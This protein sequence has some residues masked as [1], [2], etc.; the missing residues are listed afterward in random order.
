M[1][2]TLKFDQ[3]QSTAGINRQTILQV[4][5]SVYSGYASTNSTSYVAVGLSAS[6]T[7]Y[8]AT[9]KILILVNMQGLEN[10]GGS[11]TW[12]ASQIWKNGSSLQALDNVA[13]YV[14]GAGNNSQN[15]YGS[16]STSFLDSPATTA[17]TTYAI[18]WK[19]R[20]GATIYINNYADVG[21]GSTIST[22]TLLEIAQ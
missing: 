17:A 14:G 1:A 15:Y 22:M 16:V 2:S 13:N 3:W 8:Y 10:T 7:P 18:Y 19:A 12:L 6:I 21:S 4:V 11:G 9:S 20:S 5:N